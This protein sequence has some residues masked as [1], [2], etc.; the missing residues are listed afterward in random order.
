MLFEIRTAV[1]Q[2]IHDLGQQA[3]EMLFAV[4]DGQEPV[5]AGRVLRTKLVVRASCGSRAEA[6]IARRVGGD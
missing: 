6:P 3:V 2:P 5:P 4:M 1:S